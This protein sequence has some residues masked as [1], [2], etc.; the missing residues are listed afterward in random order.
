MSHHVT[1][2]HFNVEYLPPPFEEESS[3][4]LCTPGDLGIEEYA[5]DSVL[6]MHSVPLGADVFDVL[7]GSDT[8]LDVELTPNRPDCLSIRGLAREVS[9]LNQSPIL[10][11]LQEK[12]LALVAHQKKVVIENTVGKYC[13]SFFGR[14]ITGIKPGAQLPFKMV[15][16]VRRCGIP[17]V[18]PVVDI[19]NYVMLECGQPLH[20]Y[21]REKLAYDKLIVRMANGKEHFVILGGRETVLDEDTLVICDGHEAQAIAGV[22]G[23]DKSCISASTTSV[24]LECA[25]FTPQA[26]RGVA[27]RYGLHTEASYRYERGVDFLLQCEALEYATS[28]LEEFCHVQAGPVCASMLPHHFPARDKIVLRRET[29]R[30]YL[31]KDIPSQVVEASL[32]NSGCVMACAK[33][34]WQCTPRSFRFDLEVEEDLVEEVAR[35][36]GYNKLCQRPRQNVS[37]ALCPS[38]NLVSDTGGLL[39]CMLMLLVGSGYRE[40]LSYSFVDRDFQAQILGISSREDTYLALHLQN[41][42]SKNEDV[43]RLSL[44]P[45]LLKTLLY[46]L[47]RQQERVRIF[48]HGMVFHLREGVPSQSLQLGGLACGEVFPSQWRGNKSCD[49]FDIKGD[50]ERFLHSF[51]PLDYVH[52]EHPALHTGRSARI[53]LDGKDIGWLGELSPRLAERYKLDISVVLFYVELEELVSANKTFVLVPVSPYPSVRY[54]LALVVPIYLSCNKLQRAVYELGLAELQRVEI[55]DIYMGRGISDGSFGVGMRLCLQGAKKTLEK[56][57]VDTTV[58]KILCHM[59]NTYG[60]TLRN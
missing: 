1:S 13:P 37:P 5:Q 24:V 42:F 27:R 48:E 23:G 40:I 54:D 49:F 12:P 6:C 30:R 9:M 25:Y 59:Q 50:V 20:A 26:V 2:C 34:S 14:M 10:K 43:L 35:V 4:H 41:P 51:A 53:V 33:D 22:I 29:L 15:D 16:Y 45:G 60:V 11:T 7:G 18:H 3:G 19:L 58:S 52:D 21:D 44:W 55:F 46:N 57:E 17:C 47:S 32:K 31:G 56:K 38:A 28:L 36:Y 39:Q 8:V